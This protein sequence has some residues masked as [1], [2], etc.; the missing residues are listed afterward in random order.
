MCLTVSCMTH[1][2]LCFFPK[3]VRNTHQVVQLKLQRNASV[4]LNDPVVL[5]QLVTE[6]K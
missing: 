4:N 1:D 5:E 3:V 2:F 6:V